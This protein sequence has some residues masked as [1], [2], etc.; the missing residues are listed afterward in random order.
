MERKCRLCELTKVI[1]DF[2]KHPNMAGGYDSKCKECAKSMIRANRAA[3][4]ERY[5]EFDRKRA[6]LP[7][8]IEARE[9]YAKTE[10]AKVAHAR[11]GKKWVTKNS[12]RKAATVMVNNAVRDGRL[13]K[14]PCEVCGKADVQA[15]HPSYALPLVVTWLCPTH[16]AQLH[17]EHRAHLR[18]STRA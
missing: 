17:K 2:Y 8:R 13:I 3:N 1:A 16:H 4:V 15:H 14:L 10:A 11:A 5:R 18:E 9:E 12:D 7:H 6:N